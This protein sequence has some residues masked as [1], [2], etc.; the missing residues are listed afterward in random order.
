MPTQEQEWNA[1][2][3]AEFRANGGEVA[4]PYD[5]PPPMLLLLTIGARSGREHIVPMRARVE[6]GAMYGFGSPHGRERHPAERIAAKRFVDICWAL[7]PCIVL[8][9]AQ[10][11][12]IEFRRAIR[13]V[14]AVVQFS[15]AVGAAEEHPETV[16]G[17]A[18]P[19]AGTTANAQSAILRELTVPRF[20]NR[21][22]L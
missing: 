21:A 15:I 12:G 17:A 2:V 11:E 16:L 6:D 1:P 8:T 22:G 14:E 7:T 3:I 5:N 20:Q 13:A 9:A 18:I 10:V 4:A 19:A